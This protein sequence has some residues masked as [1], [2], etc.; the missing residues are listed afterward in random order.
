MGRLVDIRPDEGEL[1]AEL[2][3][4][5]GDV[6]RF[7]AT[8]GRVSSGTAVELLGILYESVVGTDGSV[9]TP[10]GAP[11]TVLV[12]AAVPGRAVVDVVTGDPFGSPVTRTV[13][14]R[15]DP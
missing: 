2:V 1:P 13:A 6:V 14:V 3:L 5:V 15:V 9:L 12:R 4:S 11:G 8:G 10:M 7:A